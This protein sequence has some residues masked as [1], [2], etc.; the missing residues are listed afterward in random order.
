[1]SYNIDEKCISC[2]MCASECPVTAIVEG[3]GKY[4]IDPSLCVDC[5]T[6]EGICPVQAISVA[7]E[8][9]K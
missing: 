3:K 7:K 9:K 6:C 1:M 2:G 8:G 4:E 5:G